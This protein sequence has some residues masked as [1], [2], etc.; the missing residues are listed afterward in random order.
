MF[1]RAFIFSFCIFLF[2]CA[3][4]PSAEFAAEKY[5]GAPYVLGP[6][7]EG[8]SAPYDTDPLRRDDAF[9]CLTFV[10]T[11][12]ADSSGIDLQKIR[13]DD[14]RIDWFA[15]NHWTET[16]WIPNVVK[17]GLIRPIKTGHSAKTFARVDFKKWYKENVA[18]PANH[19]DTEIIES[20]KPFEMSVSYVPRA[21]IKPEL[22]EKMPRDMIVFFIRCDVQN[23]AVAGD[24]IAHTGFLF[25][26][27]N[28][29]HAGQG[30]GVVHIDFLEYL[31][32][33]KFCGAAFYEVI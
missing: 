17:L 22:L 32:A 31:S 7:G 6:L 33:S 14:G 2:A 5:I 26:G 11:V 23:S 18:T 10:E 28:L 25:D 4:R 1:F 9:D 20:A 27:R 29:I 13:Y 21:D 8:A 16:E 15:R 24:I 3:G 30:T 19:A 12:L